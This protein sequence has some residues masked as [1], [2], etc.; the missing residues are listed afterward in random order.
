MSGKK[1]H[2]TTERQSRQ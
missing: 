1:M 2:M